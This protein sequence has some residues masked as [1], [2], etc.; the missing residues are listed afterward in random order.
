MANTTLQHSARERQVQEAHG[1][2]QDL[3]EQVSNRKKSW[4]RERSETSAEAG[5]AGDKKKK[6]E[7]SP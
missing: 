3:R 1:V 2:V 6:K 5:T 7:K 4:R